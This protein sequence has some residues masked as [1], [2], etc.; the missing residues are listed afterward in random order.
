VP[1]TAERLPVLEPA[2][3][4]WLPVLVPVQ[5][6]GLAERLLGPVRALE[7][8]AVARAAGLVQVPGLQ[9]SAARPWAPRPCART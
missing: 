3:A 8:A 6:L 9:P 2:R 1:V 5:V 4:E 7:P